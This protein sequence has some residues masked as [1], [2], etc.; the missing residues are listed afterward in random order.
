MSDREHVPTRSKVIFCLWLAVVITVIWLVG[1]MVSDAKAHHAKA[2]QTE[3]LAKLQDNLAVS[4]N[5]SS[6]DRA[7]SETS[8]S[9]VCGI[10]S[11]EATGDHEL[12]LHT[13]LMSVDSDDALQYARMFTG[14]DWTNN[15]PAT[16]VLIVDRRGLEKFYSKNKADSEWADNYQK[17]VERKETLEDLGLIE[18]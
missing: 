17:D 7:C 5:A 16:G 1:A 4:L 11:M 8:I 12:T 18:K 10:Q 2:D 3:W 14:D 15:D 9:W 6:W 13:D